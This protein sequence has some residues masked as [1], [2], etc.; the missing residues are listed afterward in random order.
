VDVRHA[1]QFEVGVLV[2]EVTFLATECHRGRHCF[3]MMESLARAGEDA[4][5]H[6]LDTAARDALGMPASIV[7][8]SE[9]SSRDD[10]FAGAA[11][12][13]L[14]GVAIGDRGGDMSGDLL[15]LLAQLDCRKRGAKL[16][17]TGQLDEVVDLVE[18]DEVI[19]AGADET[20]V[21]FGDHR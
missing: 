19:T 5:S 13:D 9:Y 15:A 12:A 3:A 17:R 1:I 6:Q 14:D 7:P 20:A 18:V 10:R 8:T 4:L 21:D 11:G 2:D 16:F